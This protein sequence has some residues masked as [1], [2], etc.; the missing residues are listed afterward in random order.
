[1]SRHRV[2]AFVDAIASD[3]R[4]RRFRPGAVDGRVIRAALL[5][6]AA[7]PGV[8]TPRQDFVLEL[9]R[10]L[11]R[12]VDAADAGRTRGFSVRTRLLMGVAAAVSLIG[13]T[14]AV[15]TSF[16]HALVAAKS[17]AVRVATFKSGAGAPVGQIVAYRGSPSWVFMTVHNSGATGT[18]TCMISGRDGHVLATGAFVSHGGSGE[19][20]RTV[21]GD[22]GRFQDAIV[23]SP[24]GTT[25]AT[26]HFSVS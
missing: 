22:V 16:D 19:W 10:D 17:P 5:M 25:L 12:R 7:R 20:A 4:P 15:T 9:G 8:E 13:G 11:A 26:A 18:V 3:R 23:V 2:A 24:N 6:R 21:S 14:A 1:M